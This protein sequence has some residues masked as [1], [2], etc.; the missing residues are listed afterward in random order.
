MLLAYGALSCALAV[1]AGYW[2]EYLRRSCAGLTVLAYDKQPPPPG[3]MGHVGGSKGGGERGA[4]G[5]AGAGGGGHALEEGRVV[6]CG[7]NGTDA[8][9]PG[10]RSCGG[11]RRM[12]RAGTLLG[13]KLLVYEALSYYCV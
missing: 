12:S 11:M 4:G 6:A 5:G 9:P 3:A 8:C 13:R 1:G 2:S 10:G 7:M